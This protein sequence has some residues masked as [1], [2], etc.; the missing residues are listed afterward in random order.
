[1]TTE[2]E[3]AANPD[4]APAPTAQPQPLPESTP[5]KAEKAEKA[6]KRKERD[7]VKFWTWFILLLL[8]AIFIVHIISDKCAPYTARA[9]IEAFV[10]PVAPYVAGRVSKVYVSN[11]Q[12]VKAKQK[13]IEIDKDKYELAVRQAKANLQEASQMSEADVAAVATA[14]AGVAQA[15]ANLENARI[16]G[17]RIIRL[18]K[19]GAASLAR[20]DDA[21]ARIASSEAQLKSAQSELEKAKSTLGKTGPDN[22]KV[23]AAMVALE[24][25]QL[26]LERATLRAP[27]D[28]LITNLIIDVGQYANVGSPIMTFISIRDVWIQADLRENTL[29]GIKP[30]DPVEI[31]LDVAACRVFKG[32]VRNIGW[33]V[34]DNSHD[35]LGG[36]TAVKTTHGWLRRAQ[37]FP[38]IIDFADDSTKGLR[39]VGGQANVVIYTG[40]NA[41]INACGELWIRIVSWFTIIY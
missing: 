21:R 7:P 33:G 37:R 39:R 38:V 36:L 32:T 13:L 12:F 18:S 41:V 35:Q 17:A 11:N 8:V 31:V 9:R 14:Q 1:M 6:E 26:D 25:A 27:D 19:Q 40:N 28:G 15:K 23:K 20:A 10:V 24:S 34:S 2:N 5:K 29:A 30:G 3:A 16:N 4:A 22:A